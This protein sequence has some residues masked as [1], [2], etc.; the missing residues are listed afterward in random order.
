MNRDTD[1]T[2]EPQ[3]HRVLGTLDLVLLNVA[4]IVGLRWL[5][6]AAQI[7][8]SSLT[9]WVLGLVTFLVPSALT[10]LELSSRLPGE[11]GVYLWSKAA[12]GDLHGF[13][14]G[15]SYWIAN[16]VFFPSLLLFGAAVLL[17]VPGGS[18]LALANNPLYNGAVSLSVLWFATL[19]NIVGLERAKWLQNAGAAATW[20]VGVL[21]LCGGIVA[22]HRF[23][24]ATPIAA[25]ALLPDLGS[26]A[27][28]SSFATIALAYSGL[29][30]GPIL[31]GEIKNP[32][33][34]IARALLI[35]CVAIAVLYIAGTAALFVA[36]PAQ[37]INA[38]SGVPQALTAVATRVGVPVLGVAAAALLTV[39]QMGGLGAWIT[40]TARLPFLFGL[41]RYLPKALGAVH[42]KFGS[43]HIALLTQGVLATVVLLAAISGSAI[44]EA[45]EVL[46]DMTVI[47]TFVPLL[48][49]FAALPILRRRAPRGLPGVTLIPGG[50]FACWLVGGAGFS[51]TL[52]AVLFAMV[53]PAASASRTL[54]AI[55]VVGG[56]ATL[57]L[58]GLAF[59]F[60]GR[61]LVSST[62][63][64]AGRD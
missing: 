50:S 17:Y 59:Y 3:L 49:M 39:S 32:R 11:G 41:D 1:V 24:A 8:P 29:E 23:G 31:G 51:V 5:S 14:A 64:A 26:V 13:I 10:V 33:R 55:K 57:I 16:L 43:P 34:T 27:T 47:L 21:I 9:L 56:S 60:R 58:A 18:W 45:Y 20:L 6:V 30:L 46:I 37:Q 2:S 12:F 15:W 40:G 62:I 53:P 54:F 36:L 22:W 42:P 61:R 35:A 63:R 25:P 7:G 48:Y 4:A 19:L 44:R 38:I 28:L 52:L